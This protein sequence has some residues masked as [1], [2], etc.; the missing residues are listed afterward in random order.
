MRAARDRARGLRL[1][2]EWRSRVL[3]CVWAARAGAPPNPGGLARR[4]G[5]HLGPEEPGDVRQQRR[6][7]AGHPPPHAVQPALRRP[8]RRPQLLRLLPAQA[9][10]GGRARGVGGV[11]GVG[12]LTRIRLPVRQEAAHML[13]AV[14]T[15]IVLRV[16]APGYEQ[17]PSRAR[18]QPEKRQLLSEPVAPPDLRLKDTFP[19][20]GQYAASAP[21]QR[22]G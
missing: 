21:M 16:R 6:G 8:A 12:A 15:M 4:A 19:Q 13:P 10:H 2:S 20:R 9:G 14:A 11:G 18:T 5:P 3:A 17:P 22:A 7:V 1:R